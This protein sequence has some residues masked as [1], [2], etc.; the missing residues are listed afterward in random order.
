MDLILKYAETD[1]L[2]D[3]DV[4]N[5]DL[6]S[7]D[8]LQSAV[9][10][11]LFSDRRITTEELEQRQTDKR[12]FWGDLFSDVEGDQIG[13]RLWLLARSKQTQDT[14]NRAK[15]YSE[16][17]LA[18]MIDDGIAQSVEVSTSYLGTGVML[19]EILIQKPTGKIAF[20]FKYNWD[21]E[22]VRDAV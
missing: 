15:E 16:E 12:G 20:K 17:A 2:F 7:D 13:S 21:A 22:E 5:D 8:G 1:G 10:I 6:V 9:I 11:S 18:W 19:I 4:M 3:L 14:L